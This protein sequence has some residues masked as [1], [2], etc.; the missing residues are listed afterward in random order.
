MAQA[1]RRHLQRRSAPLHAPSDLVAQPVIGQFAR[2]KRDPRASLHNRGASLTRT[3]F[4]IS[5][6][7]SNAGGLLSPFMP[8]ISAE[9]T[10]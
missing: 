1:V 3:S 2:P 4:T 7:V 5:A 6:R 10:P 8:D 9:E